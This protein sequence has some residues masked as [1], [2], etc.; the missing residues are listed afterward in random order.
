MCGAVQLFN[1][2]ERSVAGGLTNRVKEHQYEV[3]VVCQPQ[4][5]VLYIEWVLCRMVCV[6]V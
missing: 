1:H 3:D 6:C 2:L 4:Y 5:A